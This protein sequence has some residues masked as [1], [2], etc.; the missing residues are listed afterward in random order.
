MVIDEK[1]HG[2]PVG[3]LIHSNG[4]EATMLTMLD[5]VAGAMGDDFTP[6]VVIVDDAQA[7]INAVRYGV[8]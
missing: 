7:E 2:L 4:T 3:W 1:G 8:W 6:S 5:K